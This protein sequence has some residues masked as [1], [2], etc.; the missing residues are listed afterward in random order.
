MSSEE[1]DDLLLGYLD[2]YVAAAIGRV[3]ASWAILEHEIDQLIWELAGLEKEQG[4]CIT[5]QLTSVARRIDA[6]VS[7]ARLRKI[8]A[9][10]IAKFNKFRQRAGALAEKR[11]RVAHDPWHYGFDS[12]SHYRLQIT[13]KSTLD[14]TYKPMTEDDIKNIVAEIESLREQFQGL[15]DAA[16]KEYYKF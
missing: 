8:G 3:V 6:L 9:P 16:L 11:N 2:T 14:F 4:A 13:A 12:K 1:P 10:T 15:R 5:S 7:L